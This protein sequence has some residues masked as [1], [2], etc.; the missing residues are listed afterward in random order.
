M[1]SEAA[2]P[3]AAITPAE[4]IT[5]SSLKQV[6]TPKPEVIEKRGTAKAT[7][8]SEQIPDKVKEIPLGIIYGNVGTSTFNVSAT[9]SLEKM[10]Y[11]EVQT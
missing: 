9:S 4:T 2:V 8:V 5:T 10:E 3:T 1:E 6:I 7:E 11:I